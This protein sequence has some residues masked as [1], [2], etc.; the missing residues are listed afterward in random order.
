MPLMK[1]SIINRLWTWAFRDVGP[2]LSGKQ[3]EEEFS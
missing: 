3:G 1:Q 2:G